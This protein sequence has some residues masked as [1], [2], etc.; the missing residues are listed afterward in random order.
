MERILGID[1]NTSV[2][3]RRSASQNCF[4]TH[5][6]MVSLTY[7]VFNGK[8]ECIPRNVRLLSH[9]ETSFLKCSREIVRKW[10]DSDGIVYTEKKKNAEVDPRVVPEKRIL[11]TG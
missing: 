7:V 9:G 5:C 1:T 11:Y 3:T 10:W 6:C 8:L 4:I 2:S